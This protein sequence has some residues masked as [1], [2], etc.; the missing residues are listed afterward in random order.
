MTYR[1]TR[2]SATR[3]LFASAL[4]LTLV[5]TTLPARADVPQPV[6]AAAVA[7]QI[8]TR[9]RAFMDFQG[10]QVE[11]VP[12]DDEST[13]QGHF[14][15]IGV[16]C[17]LATANQF[18]FR[19]F[20]IKASDVTLKLEKLFADKPQVEKLAGGKTEISGRVLEADMNAELQ[21]NGSWVQRSSLQNVAVHFED[22]AIRFT[23][24][25]KDLLGAQVEVTGTLKVREATLLD[26]SPTEVKVN[27]I[28]V[29]MALVRSLMKK[30]NPLYNFS[31]L[32]L[33]PTIDKVTVTKGYI[34]VQ[35]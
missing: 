18:A 31:D 30:L 20:R 9:L 17:D 21:K 26:F 8:E 34:L 3:L 13:Q 5:N 19:D 27:G 29:P 16:S 7:K 12:R 10:L 24:Q 35:G 11:V 14:Q 15:S 2:L 23:G 22:D 6:T 28:P 32:P 4:A 25:C 1:A 33:Q